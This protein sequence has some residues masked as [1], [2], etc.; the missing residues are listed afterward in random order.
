MSTRE[1]KEKRLRPRNN[2]YKRDKFNQTEFTRIP[3][4][5]KKTQED[6]EKE[7]AYIE[8]VKGPDDDTDYDLLALL[9]DDDLLDYLP[10]DD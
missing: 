1:Q 2:P 8:S 5:P 6:K 9:A 7:R 10:E 3:K 4:D